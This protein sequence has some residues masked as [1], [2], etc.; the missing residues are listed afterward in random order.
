M[1]GLYVYNVEK[2]LFITNDFPPQRGGI[3]TFIE[4]LI[5]E[6]PRDSVVVHTSTQRAINDQDTFDQGIF[7]DLGVIVVRDRQKIL[8]PT[9]SLRNRIAG[10]IHAHSIKTVVFGASVPLGLLAPWLRQLGITR[11][12]AITHGHEVWWSKVPLFSLMLRRVGAHV[13]VITHLGDFTRRSISSALRESDLRKLVPLPPGVNIEQFHPGVKPEYLITRYG[14]HGKRIILCVGRLVQRKG[15]DVLISA[16]AKVREEIPEAHLLFV[17]VGNHERALR[18]RALKLALTG[19]VTFAG[20]AGDGE[21]ADHF[22]VADIFASPTRNRFGGLEV[23]G[24][25]IVYLEASAS[26]LA[27]IAGNSGGSPDAVQPEITGVVVDGRDVDALASVLTDL[28]KNEERRKAL[29]SAGRAWME[30][31]WSWPIIGAR[32]R[33]LLELN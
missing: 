10:T 4:G 32:F 12:V 19:H 25:G 7:N 2:V 18:K 27:V 1:P 28:L 31:Q 29:G 6:L 5:R 26:G 16:L 20:R 30:A 33:S 15:Q 13:D 3:Q 14:V 23:E 24:L 11:I 8:L 21:L 9:W 22:R 17:G